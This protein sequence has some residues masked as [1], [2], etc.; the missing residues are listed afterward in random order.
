MFGGIGDE[1]TPGAMIALDSLVNPLLKDRGTL[2]NLPSLC[3]LFDLDFLVECLLERARSVQ[4]V[5][6]V[7]RLAALRVA[8][9]A[10]PPFP[11]RQTTPINSVCAGLRRGRKIRIT[12]PFFLCT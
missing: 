2:G 9:D 1:V 4:V 3:T 11:V 5:G 6:R 7:L 8:A 12:V 10:G